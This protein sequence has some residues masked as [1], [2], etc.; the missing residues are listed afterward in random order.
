MN[1]SYRLSYEEDGVYIEATDSGGHES[2]EDILAHIERKNLQQVKMDQAL[3]MLEDASCRVCIAPPQK[4][5]FYNEQAL[6]TISDNQMEASV[7]LMPADTGGESMTYE[8][9]LEEAALKGICRGIDENILKQVLRDKTY[10][11]KICFAEGIMPEEGKDGELI[12]HFNTQCLDIPAINE[13]DGKVD[14]KNLNLFVH[15]STGQK[16]ISRIP[17]SAGSPGYTVTGRP[18]NPKSRKEAKLPGGKNI[19]YDDKRLTMFA[20]IA[21]R[22]DYKNRTVIV[23]SCY[24][25]AGDADLSTGNITFDGDVIIKGNVIS[26]IT[27]KVTKNI[28]VYGTVEGAKLIAGGNIVLRSGIHGNGKGVLEA[29]GDVIAKYIERTTVRA[30]GNIMV[31]VLMHCWAESGD[32][33]IAK[34]KHGSIIGGTI[35]AQNSITAQN[36]GSVINNKTTLEVGLPLAKR[37]RLKHLGTELERL[38]AESEKYDKIANYLTR[39]VNIP[40]EKEQM[41][42]TVIV[43]KLQNTKLIN[44]Y[45]TEMKT[46]REDVGKA[47]KGKVHVT[48]TIYPG[49]RLTISLGEYTVAAPMK[50]STFYC[51]N[52]E[53]SFTSCQI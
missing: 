25:V 12:F 11:N 43:G 4:E 2:K 49:T 13:K 40:P 32:G 20:A 44:E 31:D 27:V 34:G 19:T 1:Q 29:E 52:R 9:L 53:I 38:Y 37:A 41:K 50:Y 21:G 18:I 17:A 23:S 46:L 14:Y 28:E 7:C 51:E 3:Q 30:R 15:V 45:L 39:M 35:K 10:S 6:I 42:K 24:T 5:F 48:D 47:E 33:I 16:L 8:Q 22:V 26:D 36:I